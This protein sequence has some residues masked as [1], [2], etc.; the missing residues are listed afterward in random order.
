MT[1]IQS[2]RILDTL[3]DLHSTADRC[4]SEL[5]AIATNDK[6]TYLEHKA[7][8][9]RAVADLQLVIDKLKAEKV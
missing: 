1:Y 4:E 5:L 3:S 2:E 7:A 6:H 9:E 8:F